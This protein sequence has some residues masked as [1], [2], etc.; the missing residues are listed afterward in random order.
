MAA[1]GEIYR[2]GLYYPFYNIEVDQWLKAAALYWPS[3]VRLMPERLPLEDSATAKIL[4]EELDFIVQRPPGESVA[5]ASERYL[6]LITAHGDAL[7]RQFGLT[8]AMQRRIMPDSRRRTQLPLRFGEA[9]S[10]PMD[11]GLVHVAKMTPAL[12][13]AL[14]CNGL[15]A[16]PLRPIAGIYTQAGQALIRTPDGEFASPDDPRIGHKPDFTWIAIHDE[17]AVLYSSLLA[18]DFAA[19]NRL[20]PITSHTSAFTNAQDWTSAGLAAIL[21]G[22]SVP[23]PTMP[24]DDLGQHVGL[25]ALEYVVPAQ[26]DSLP[27]S[28]IIEIRRRYESEFL[29]FS[30]EVSQ[31]AADLSELT[32]VRD[33]AVLDLYVRDVVLSRFVKPMQELRAVLKGLKLDSATVAVNIR[34]E[35]PAGTLLAAG[36]YAT[37]HSLVAGSGAAAIGLLAMRRGLRQRRHCALAAAPVASFL[38]QVQQATQPRGLLDQTADRVQRIIGLAGS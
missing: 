34:T 1:D 32:N 28:K 30:R 9:D 17:L 33:E 2:R 21:L 29:A 16:W 5:T 14:I 6:K 18:S 7:R 24:L 10:W 36:A 31:A 4:I 19:A 13:D 11:F 20:A 25:L 22:D 37:G 15:A 8:R 27:V 12:R 26:L 23:D 3:L 35:L 38:L